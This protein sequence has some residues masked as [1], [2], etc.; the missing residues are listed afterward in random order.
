MG[1]DADFARVILLPC[2]CVDIFCYQEKARRNVLEGGEQDGNVKER[3]F[4]SLKS[5]WVNSFERK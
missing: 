5:R 3:N 1:K 2:F 4:S